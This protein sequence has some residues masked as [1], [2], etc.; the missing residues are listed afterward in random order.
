MDIL[1]LWMAETHMYLST[2]RVV[3]PSY[4]WYLS[5]IV[6]MSPYK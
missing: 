1:H 5:F 4:Q 2:Y 3:S 6:G